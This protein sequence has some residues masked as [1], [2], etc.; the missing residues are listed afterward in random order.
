[1]SL[2]SERS[3]TGREYGRLAPIVLANLVPLVGVSRL[4]W[5]PETLVV[6]Y[7]VE[8]LLSL[9][10]AAAK[11]LFAARPPARDRDDGVIT[12][13]SSPLSEKRG[14]VRPVSWL[15]PVY[16]RNVPFALAVCGTAVW[17]A[18]GVGIVLSQTLDVAEAIRR[19]G[20]LASA[21][22]LFAG[23]LVD[24]GRTYFLRRRYEETSPYAVVETP[25]RQ[26]VFLTVVGFGLPILGSLG[27]VAPLVALV[28]VKMFVEWSAVRSTGG[29]SGDSGSEDGGTEWDGSEGDD[30]DTAGG[31]TDWLAGPDDAT[32]SPDSVSIPD[33]TPDER[34]PAHRRAAVAAGVLRTLTVAAPIYATLTFIAWIAF[35]GLF[36][37][38]D[39]SPPV[40]YGSLV[41][42]T[43]LF[44]GAVA[45]DIVGYALRDGTVE[46]RR[47]GDRIVAHDVWLDEP[48]WDASLDFVRE[49]D[50]VH[51]R[52][53][54]RVLGART[55]EATV[56][57]GDGERERRIGPVPDG[58][59]A[60]KAFDLPVGG[61]DLPPID[62]RAAALAAGVALAAVVGTALWFTGPWSSDADVVR[63][64]FVLPFVAALTRFLWRQTYVEPD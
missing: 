18:I 42:A 46:Y 2:R 20:V 31:L 44:V 32:A 26:A 43:A 30:E 24:A 41:A 28:F 37:G 29:D 23:Q 19:P 62:R 64:V 3:S 10:V 56:G 54:D 47:Y 58:T 55:F 61:T 36:V 50:V 15:P 40:A 57:Y 14:A 60:V 8:F 9:L 33:R 6:V 4:G 21:L 27:G 25:A 45:V 48:Q 16:P 49:V 12:A 5:D 59:A 13:T 22:A 39:A 7:V 53:P 11:A 17:V 63:A 38:G 34:V 52:L 1:M 51:T 35:F